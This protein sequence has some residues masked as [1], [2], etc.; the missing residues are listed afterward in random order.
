V[1][2]QDL[3]VAKQ[4]AR[5]DADERAR[6]DAVRH[7]E[8]LDT[9]PDGAFDRITAM[10]A[11]LFDVPIAIVSIVDTDRIWFKSRFGLPDVAQI[12]R[13]PGLC[14]SAILNREPWVVTDAAVDPRTLANPLVAG[15]F[16][17]RFYAGAPLTTASGHNLGTLCVID[18]EPRD[19]SAREL[20]VLTG[21][22][23]LVMDQLELRLHAR[24]LVQ[25]ESE[26]RRDAERL[27]DVLQ[28]SLLPPRPPSVPGME[29]ATRFIAGERGLR[30][31]GDFYDVFRRGSNDW[32]IVLGDVCG[33]GAAAAALAAS[34]R[35]TVRA[36]AGHH[37]DPHAVLEDLNAALLADA[38]PESDTSYLSAAFARL[39]LDTCGA[40][41][42]L[43]SSGHPL[44]VLVRASGRVET[45]GETSLPLGLFGAVRPVEVRV[46][47]GPG[48]SLVFYTDGVTDARGPD[49][50]LFGVERLLE[51]LAGCPGCTSEQIATRVIDAVT[52]FAST[53]RADDLA[54]LVV[55]VPE[56]ASVDP[57]G[58]VTTATGV[59]EVDLRLPGYPHGNA[60]RQEGSDA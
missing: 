37:L 18:R 39:E 50:E 1:T 15:A 25:A 58:R 47:L 49:G 26:L 19:V 29:L 3:L 5:L 20:D 55:G 35:W 34:A 57:I 28:A 36:S 40:W 9:P 48:D 6:L 59:D 21:L 10:A 11:H 2:A 14:A 54:L 41:L 53:D 8:I 60:A 23:Q 32:A 27:A 7:F 16:G 44:P 52:S 46:G 42:T 12:D 22:A 17:L 43:A 33:K 38:D 13:A 45:C 4:R 51:L 24:E 31:G 30:V 56:D